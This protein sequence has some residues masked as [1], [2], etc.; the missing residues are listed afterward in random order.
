MRT[1]RRG[2]GKAHGRRIG[3]LNS[4]DDSSAAAS[5]HNTYFTG[6][7]TVEDIAEEL[8]HHAASQGMSPTHLEESLKF[9]APL[10][11]D[12]IKISGMITEHC[13]LHGTSVFPLLDPRK[14]QGLRALTSLLYQLGFSP[15]EVGKALLVLPELAEMSTATMG[16]RVLR[17]K[18]LG[19]DGGQITRL[20]STAPVVM[21]WEDECAH[22]SPTGIF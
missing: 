17:C 15:T 6:N 2:S 16:L 10:G 12:V 20:I 9:L 11:V 21:F 22:P 18:A 3:S 13:R 14:E 5:R 7:S 8:V 19:M 4:L 1:E